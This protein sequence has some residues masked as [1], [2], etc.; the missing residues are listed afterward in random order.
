V[1]ECA[2]TEV[3]KDIGKEASIDDG[4]SRRKTIKIKKHKVS[5]LTPYLFEQNNR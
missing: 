4:K 5:L 1:T 3:T 2:L